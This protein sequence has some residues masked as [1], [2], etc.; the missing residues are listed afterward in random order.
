[1]VNKYEIMK[2][3]MRKIDIEYLEEYAKDIKEEIAYWKDNSEPMEFKYDSDENLDDGTY[4]LE[5][6]ENE[7]K[8][9]K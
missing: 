1:M 5:Y 7:L 6:H 2:H 8:K 9:D 3:I 4:N